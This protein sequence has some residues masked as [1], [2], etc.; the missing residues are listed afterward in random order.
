MAIQ[1]RCEKAIDLAYHGQHI[2]AGIKHDRLNRLPYLPSVDTLTRLN[3]PKL[4][5][6]IETST[7]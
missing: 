1:R 2:A 3:I 5:Q 7:N 4:N 6:S